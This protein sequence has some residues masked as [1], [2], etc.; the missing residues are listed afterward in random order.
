MI[1]FL[2]Q[3]FKKYKASLTVVALC[4]VL[5]AAVNLSEPFLTAK[6]ID[7]ILIGQDAT[8]FY[9]FIAALA[10][11]SV[12]AIA[13]NW[14]ST[15][16]SS[17]MRVQINNRVVEDVLRHVCKV[18]GDF[19]FK[20]DMVYLSK[21]LDQDAID[22]VYFAIGSMVD[23][24]INFA[25]LCM[26]FGLMCS[27]GVKWGVLFVIIAAAHGGVYR[28]L[29]RIL[30]ER[31]TD[32]RETES[33]YFTCLSDILLYVYSIKL[34]GLCGEWFEKFRAAFEKSFVAVMRQV[35]IIFW[36][37]TSSLNANAVFKVLI[38]LLG[39][40]D[41]LDGTLT[42][43][44]FVA[45]NGYYLLAMQGVAYF[46]SVGQ[47]YQNALAAYARIME[48]KNLPTE[49]NG[50]KIL[51]RIRSIELRNVNF[52][53]EEQKILTNFNKRFER[54]KIYCIIGKNGAGKSTLMNLICGM[55]RPSGGEIFFD[56]V[57]LAEVDMI[58]ARKNLIA[59]VEQKD[60]I[61]NDKLSGGERRRESINIALKKF[62]DV[63]IMDE[64][65]NNLDTNAIETLTQKIFDGKENRITLIIS[66]DKR[67][68]DI[69]DEITN[70]NA[71]IQNPA[72]RSERG[73]FI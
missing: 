27:L 52:S 48:I 3:H 30:F 55:I 24:C 58:H 70:L 13:A 46:M 57:A 64:P 22:L 47:N 61:K 73:F 66:H 49:K 12:T 45:L 25:L 51:E 18:R 62:A 36:F 17:K 38:F 31:S 5:T 35:K 41:V 9:V 34:H 40:L 2:W 63:L 65:D 68:I 50:T 8:T 59:V 60:F 10:A 69:A 39:G 7:E 26:A 29:E 54:G 67:L 71:E 37:S 28:A 21:R 44:N 32:V 56:G 15:I 42:V 72:P 1:K 53:F 33:R 23:I 19:I 6:F 14:L 16:L 4:S 11:I 43:G 20:T